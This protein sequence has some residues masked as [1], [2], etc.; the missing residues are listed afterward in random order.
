MLNLLLFLILFPFAVAALL[1]ATGWHVEF[2]RL[3]VKTGAAVL[4]VASVAVLGFHLPDGVLFFSF[5]EPRI[6]WLIKGLDVALLLILLGV[7]LRAR[8]PLITALVVTQACLMWMLEFGGAHANPVEA[9]LFYDNFSGIMAHIV[10]MIGGLICLHAVGYM[11]VYNDHH[12]ELSSKARWF[13]VTL[14]VFLGAMF[15]MI[16]SNDLNWIF[17]CWEITTL[18]SFLLIGHDKTPRARE[19][20]YLAL[21]INML[22][23]LAFSGALL[24]LARTGGS[25]ALYDLITGDAKLVMIPVLLIC[26]AG[27][28]KAAQMPFSSWLLGAM[29]APTPVSALLHSSTMVKAGVYIIIRFA[30]VLQGT[31]AGALIALVG[32]VT[33][34]FASC[35]AV[36]QSNAKRVLAY[37]T[38]A[39]LGLIVTCAGVGNPQAVWAAVLLIIFHAVA[40]ALLFIAVGS[41]DHAIGS[42]DIEDMEGLI[43]RR[44]STAM[45]ILIGI[46]GMF[47]APFGMLISK[48]AAIEA[49]LKVNPV[50]PVIV[51]FGSAA[52]LF[53]WAKWMGK[54]LSTLKG[55]YPAPREVSGEEKLAMLGLAILTVALCAGWP[56]ISQLEINPYLKLFYHSGVTL[57]RVTVVIMSCMMGLIAAL[58]L[59]LLYKGEKKLRLT[60]PYLSG[61]NVADRSRFSASMG[62]DKAVASRNYYLDEFF[63]ESRLTKMALAASIVLLLAL[64]MVVKP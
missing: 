48:W 61:A 34:L 2:R 49:L 9:P 1:A 24:Y 17:L 63:K 6:E 4:A 50:L 29:V 53:F 45:A 14:F 51:A 37:S 3:V 20:S 10:G 5:H 28:T 16:F 52:T 54:I 62:A 55:S 44:P 41:V 38:I 42:L 15:G 8:K 36:T 26:V 64:L 35:I 40:K 18:C 7:A 58:P 47:L 27:L 21:R 32:A 60:D 57:H 13:P 25:F 31:V 12:P 23:G 19:N 33:F 11:R 43:T 30:P 22:G 46:A 56:V 39:N 59:S